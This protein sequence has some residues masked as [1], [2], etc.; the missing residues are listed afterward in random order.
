MAVSQPAGPAG[1]C[2][3]TRHLNKRGPLSCRSAAALRPSREWMPGT[4]DQVV[5]AIVVQS[6][7]D[8][9]DEVDVPLPPIC[10]VQLSRHKKRRPHAQVWISWKPD[11]CHASRAVMP[12]FPFMLY[13]DEG[14]ADDDA[15]ACM[16]A[17]PI[18]GGITQSTSYKLAH[19]VASDRPPG[20]T[21]SAFRLA[22]TIV[23]PKRRICTGVS[24]ER[25]LILCSPSSLQPGTGR[26]QG[27]TVGEPI[28]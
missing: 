16:E 23:S 26:R 2:C 13:V 25:P 18:D 5:L 20:A 7:S 12:D 24:D 8:S 19:A 11:P 6:A 27:A 9:D 1:R 10:F 4:E 3:I 17:L 21:T 22:T 15:D 28:R 14:A